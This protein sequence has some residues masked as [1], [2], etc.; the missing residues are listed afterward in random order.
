MEKRILHLRRHIMSGV[1]MA[2]AFLSATTASAVDPCSMTTS[3]SGG[4][5]AQNGGT[6]D[7]AGGFNYEMWTNSGN[8]ASM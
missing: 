7:I 8:N 6:H 5:R 1:I 2:A 3:M 4:Q